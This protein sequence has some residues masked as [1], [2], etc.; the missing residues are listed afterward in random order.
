MEISVPHIFYFLKPKKF[1]CGRLFVAFRDLD[2]F[3]NIPEVMTRCQSLSLN[4][5]ISTPD[6]HLEDLGAGWH[7]HLLTTI[8]NWFYVWKGSSS[9]FKMYRGK[10]TWIICSATPLPGNV[11]RSLPTSS[12]DY[13]RPNRRS[14][15]LRGHGWSHVWE[16]EIPVMLKY[17]AACFNFRTPASSIHP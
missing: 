13:A 8:R 7:G 14:S 9:I 11:R 6:G 15:T 4:H 3:L 17:W 10:W 5:E 2:Y 12:L 1:D 16:P